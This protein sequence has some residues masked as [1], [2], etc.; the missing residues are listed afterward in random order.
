M[1]ILCVF[2]TMK[3]VSA[4]ELLPP[5]VCPGIGKE[6]EYSLQVLCQYLCVLKTHNMA[7]IELGLHSPQG[8]SVKSYFDNLVAGQFIGTLKLHNI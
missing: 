4:L 7:L 1:I 5:S 8:R 2:L 3:T 6:V